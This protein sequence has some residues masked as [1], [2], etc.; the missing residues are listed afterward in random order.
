MNTMTRRRLLSLLLTLALLVTLSPA[1][2][3]DG[4]EEGDPSP[5]YTLTGVTLSLTSVTMKVGETQSL[6]AA[7]KINDGSGDTE[8]RSISDLPEGCELDVKWTVSNDRDDEVTVT[9]SPSNSLVATLD[10]WKV[11]ETTEINP[12]TVTATVTLNG[13]TG[14]SQ[15]APPCTVKVNP[16]DPTGLTVSP[17]TLELSYLTTVSNHT[18]GLT[19]SI[20]PATADQTVTWRSGDT[21]VATVEQDGKSGALVTG[22]APGTT[23]IYASSPL[24]AQEASCSV[25]VM[26]VVLDKDAISGSHLRVGDRMEL[27]YT[28]YGDSL[29]NRGVTWSTSDPS[30]LRVDSGYLYG[31]KAGTAT[32]TVQVNGFSSYSDSMTVTVEE[33]TAAV[34]SASAQTGSPLSFSSLRSD[35]R[36]RCSTVLGKSLNYISGLSVPTSQGTLYYRY[37]SEGDT[38]TGIGTGER[39]YVSPGSGQMGLS[40]ITFVPKPDFSGTAEI[41]YTG[42]VDGTTFF[43][44]TIEVSVEAQED[45]SY[46]TANG[47]PVQLV[48]SDF[49]LVCRQRTGRDLSYVIFS[50]PDSDTGTLYYNYLSAQNPGTA[51]RASSQYYYSGTP[52]LGSVFFV[53]ASGF[54]GRVVI[55]Y[56]AYN[57]NRDSF[58]GRMVIQVDAAADTGSIRYSV[59]QGERVSFDDSDF[60]PLSRDLTGSSLDYVRFTLPVSSQGTLYYNYTSSSSE[61]VSASKNYYRSSAPYLDDVSFLASSSFTGTV[62]IPF[63]GRSLD[64]TAFSGTVSIRVGATGDTITYT[65]TAGKAVEFQ[66]DDFNEL[67]RDV[68]GETLRY[69]R[70]TLPSSSRGTLYYDYDDGDYGSKVSSSQNYYR[71]SSPYLNRVSFA[72]ASSYS[73]TVSISFTGWSTGGEKFSGTVEIKVEEKA[74]SAIIYYSTAYNPV[75]FQVSDFR[76]A[77]TDQGLSTLKSVQF[78]SAVSSSAGHLYN[79]YGGFRAANSEVRT[80][81]AYTPGGTADLADVTFV[82]RVGYSGIV[83]ISYTGTDTRGKTFQG[84]VRITVSPKAS[85][86]YFTD[87]SYGYSWCASSVDFLYENGVVN[88]TGGGLYSPNRAISRG[89]FLAMVDRALNLPRTSQ[90]S[91]S[92]VPANSYYADAIQAAYA[93]GIVDGYGD[94]TFRPDAPVTRAAAMTMLYRAMN[95]VGWSVGSENTALLASYPD[96]GSVPAYARGP[97]SAMLQSGIIN[98]TSS[99]TLAPNRT[100]TRAEMAVVLARALTM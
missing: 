54:D 72:A 47:E 45:V 52:A 8:Y 65:V 94:G 15:T 39:F 53:P 78:T 42:Y 75:V 86:S 11:A 88:G 89:S 77:C 57:T 19:A 100:M 91:F 58:Q 23:K 9:P 30:I 82:P 55:Y 63:T 96:G 37:A 51:V 1:A 29:Q 4:E 14:S 92:D 69:V 98:G 3:A 24:I 68:T 93:L 50:L 60:N 28:I 7:V 10:A 32:V 38:G 18:A 27:P 76:N 59:A 13:D 22:K 17:S 83:V 67:S 90:R 80:N 74:N 64:G 16:A 70:F 21:S 87:L 48:A 73:G 31:V 46:S 26:G 84:Q 40:E 56:T 5:T 62:S 85:S 12:L 34:I 71:S 36:D 20:S 41:S 43:Q 25:T 97:M 61:R 81:T 35:F 2:L 6:T 95:A 99:G 66:A 44:G 79:G 33:S 49:A